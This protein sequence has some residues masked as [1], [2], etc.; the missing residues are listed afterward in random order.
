MKNKVAYLNKKKK[1]VT[2]IEIIVAIAVFSVV[3]FALFSSIIAM[4]KVIIRQEEYVRIEMVCHDISA[5]REKYEESW[6]T[7]YFDGNVKN[8]GY[9]T[10]NFN[11]TTDEKEAKYKIIFSKNEIRS[12]STMN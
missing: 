7:K 10:S 1:G 8:I 12:I 3:S 6:A 2:L 9:L 11:P 4:K 5:Y